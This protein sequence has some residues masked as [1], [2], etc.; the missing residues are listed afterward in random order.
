MIERAFSVEDTRKAIEEILQELNIEVELTAWGTPEIHTTRCTLT[1]QKGGSAIG[2]GKGLGQQ[3]ENSAIF[4][5]V[6]HYLSDPRFAQ[7]FF[8]GQLTM[9]TAEST[10]LGEKDT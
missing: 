5:A 2:N 9:Q 3:S 7:S 6:E 1:D 8:L 10:I 4:E